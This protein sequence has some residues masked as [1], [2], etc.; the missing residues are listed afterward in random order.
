VFPADHPESDP[1][2]VP[3]HGQPPPASPSSPWSGEASTPPPASPSSTWPANAARPAHASPSSPWSGYSAASLPVP[4]S[5]WSRD[6]AAAT[7]SGSLSPS[8]PGP[9]ADST[10]AH[11]PYRPAAERPAEA[12]AS[13]LDRGS[14]DDLAIWDHPTATGVGTAPVAP[15]RRRRAPSR[16]VFVAAIC[17]ISGVTGA[18]AALGAV[19]V[20]GSSP[21]RGAPAAAAANAQNAAAISTPSATSTTPSATSNSAAAGSEEATTIQ[22]A[23]TVAP[24]VVTIQV[25]SQPTSSNNSPLGGR[26]PSG[27]GSG[28]IIKADGW[29]LTN[30][31]VVSDAKTATVILAD[32]RQF[33]G[34]VKGVDTLTD[35][36]LVKVD[37]NDLPTATLGD[38]A[39]VQV[40]QTAIAIGSPLGEFPG[41]VTAGIVSGLDRT[42]SVADAASQSGSA[43]RHL[44]QTDA[45]IN[46]GNS[47]GALLDSQGRVIGIN[48]AE[49]SQAQAIGFALPIDLA[50]PIIAQAEAGQT[51]TRPWIGI[52]YRDLDAQ[53][54][55]D[56]SLSV[57]QG[58]WIHRAQGSTT[59][60]VVAGSPAEKAGLTDGDIITGLDGQSIDS[61]HPLDLLLL[62][63]Q[64]GDTVALTVLRGNSTTQIDLTL[65]T[66]PASLG[67][68]GGLG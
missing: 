58:A 55:K 40:G 66:R 56:Q 21:A 30:H 57:N 28:V 63:K 14:A 8:E 45:A 59:P 3:D 23:A 32:G 22:I 11:W 46:P 65:G 43:L 44:I 27:S 31:H 62:G 34:T 50:K 64:P 12:P 29:I 33:D 1:A 42:I 10:A 49:A 17:L 48:T 38:S 68:A 20:T 67:L 41:S 13:P 60:A 18:A 5:P 16:V 51:I 36:A 53:V 4:G 24:A 26:Q 61:T 39:S 15:V 37:A 47:G 52:V 6:A 54:A 19:A 7:S 9:S 25:G 35:F 2:A